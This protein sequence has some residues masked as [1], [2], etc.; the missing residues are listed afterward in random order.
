MEDKGKNLRFGDLVSDGCNV[1]V[2]NLKF[3]FNTL[4]RGGKKSLAHE[5]G[6][7]QTTVSRWLNGSNEPKAYNLRQM[8]IY[9]GLKPETDLRETPVFLSVEPV[10]LT[11]RRNWLHGRLNAL[12]SYDLRELYPALRRLLEEKR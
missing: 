1:L 12:S 7:A 8:I 5:L 3:L 4:G 6:V 10:A 9:F 2:E 11:D